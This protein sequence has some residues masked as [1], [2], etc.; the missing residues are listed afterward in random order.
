V[1]EK[2]SKP[3]MTKKECFLSHAAQE[4]WILVL[5]HAKSVEACTVKMDK[6]GKVV[7]DKMGDLEDF[8]K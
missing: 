5:E 3:M 1:E 2:G 4:K 7:V 8:L 6:K